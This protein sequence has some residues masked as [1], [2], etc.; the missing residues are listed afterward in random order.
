[1]FTWTLRNPADSIVVA[2]DERLPWPHTM[3]LGMQHV[4][5]M[6]GSTVL[7][8]LLMGFDPNIA[9]LM[10][11][12]GTLI[13]FI[14]TAGK[15]P[16][17]VGSS[18]AFISVVIVSSGYAGKGPN[19]N[20][21]VAL[22]GIVA[23]GAVYGLIGVGV[24][25]SGTR[26]IERLMPPVVTGGIVAVIGL[27]LAAIPVKNMAPTGF[28]A[29]MQVVTFMSIGVVAVFT[30]GMVR[31]LLILVGLILA[32]IIYAVL[33][34]GMGIGTPIDTALVAN[35]AW[36]GAPQFTSPVFEA[37]AIAMIVPVALILVAENLGHLK[38]VAAM[39]GRDM[40][41]FI[42]RAFLGDG[43]ATMVSGS[44]GGTGV[45]TYAENIGV[46]AATRIYS[47]APFLVAASFALLLGF[48]PKFGALIQT[49]PLAVMGGVSIVVF[50]LIAVAGARIWFD[51]KVDFADSRSLLVA[52]I[53]L[54]LGTGDFTLK[55]FGFTI[56]GIG[57]ATFGA[58][59]LNAVLSR[60]KR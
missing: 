42:G 21:G 41:P 56:G 36:F 7:A 51:N 32:S 47:T 8:P 55:F 54:V 22:G 43:I 5:A 17:Y 23:C 52:A 48:S 16:S 60:G 30:G 19:A 13:F 40:D 57:T 27:N 14:V 58:I 10:S 4:V 3:A 29:W 53:T 45:T 26:W 49:I 2:P 38:A 6:F 59:V 11:G 20:I 33:T 15:V 34:N 18:F 25:A 50:G 46:M 31:R 44:V 37:R 39:T 35:A 28:D 24:I 1:M 12:V 9:V